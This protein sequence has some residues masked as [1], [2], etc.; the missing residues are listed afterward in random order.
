MQNAKHT[1]LVPMFDGFMFDK[2]HKAYYDDKLI[3]NETSEF[4]QWDYK[5][6][7]CERK[8]F[9]DFTLDDASALLERL[10]WLHKISAAIDDGKLADGEVLNIVVDWLACLCGNDIIYHE[11]TYYT[12]EKGVFKQGIGKDY[13]V[14]RALAQQIVPHIHVGSKQRKQ[15]YISACAALKRAKAAQ[16]AE[17]SNKDIE[18]KELAKSQ[19][20]IAMEQWNMLHKNVAGVKMV[21]FIVQGYI[22]RSTYT[23]SDFYEKLDAQPNL[24]AFNN[25]VFDLYSG[26]F[27]ELRR[28]DYISTTTG[29]DWIEPDE[30]AKNEFETLFLNKVFVDIKVRTHF[31]KTLCASLDG[32]KR[33]HK[34]NIWCNFGRNGKSITMNA[35][36]KMLGGYYGVMNSAVLQTCKQDAGQATPQFIVLKTCRVVS[37][38]EP[39]VSRKLNSN[40][41]KEMS[42]GDP[43]TLRRL[44]SSAIETFQPMAMPTM[45]CND[46]PNMDRN[47]DAI[48]NRLDIIPFM[49][50]FGVRPDKS[51]IEKDNVDK[52]E[53][54]ADHSIEGRLVDW[55]CCFFKSI[56]KH[57][58]DYLENPNF[59]LE[60]CAMAD[61]YQRKQDLVKEFMDEKMKRREDDDDGTGER[62]KIKDIVHHLNKYLKGKT[63]KTY[64]SHT[65]A[66]YYRTNKYKCSKHG[67]DIYLFHY[68]FNWEYM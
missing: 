37:V 18:S 15:A 1:Q 61:D 66:K 41:I 39:E 16:T 52:M 54:K 62:T 11:N 30:T 20:K 19:A 51:I 50:T 32:T 33:R 31:L 35:I 17:S 28:T 25:C 4:I 7:V 14:K 42:G 59:V 26:K 43:I 27:R 44:Y 46:I 47:D 36:S 6:N 49:S 9:L 38:N 56:V 48:M 58:K 24:I 13:E 60:H 57:F 3:K 2:S 22:E 65:L 23:H 29:Y 5:S 34:F 63:D 21:H 45:P 67:S 12:Y 64:T 55:R 68:V 10:E 8:A 53:F 40:L